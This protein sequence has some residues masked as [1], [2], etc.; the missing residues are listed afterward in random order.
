MSAAKDR[1][2]QR[3]RRDIR[4]GHPDEHQCQRRNGDRASRRKARTQL[5]KSEQHERQID[6]WQP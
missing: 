6:D 3:I 4:V 2:Q 5:V 1:G